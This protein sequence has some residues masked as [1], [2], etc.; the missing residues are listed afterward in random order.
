VPDRPDHALEDL[1]QE[2][3][4]DH[5]RRPRNKG[6]LEPHTHRVG[7]TNPSCGDELELDLVVAGDTISDVRFSGRGC[8][9]SQASASM[10]TQLIK[11]KTVVHAAVPAEDM[12]QAFAYRHLVPANDLWAFVAGR[13]PSQAALKI[14]TDLP[15]KIAAG[16]AAKVQIS[17]PALKAFEKVE[18]ELNEPPAGFS[19]VKASVTPD[20]ADVIVQC[21]GTKVKPGLKGNLIVNIFGVRTTRLPQGTLPAIPFEVIRP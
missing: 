3:I 21:D 15:L 14:R 11:G 6:T 16:Q 19:I 7:L 2:L 9:I 20:G 1:F 10:M 17:L 18:F 8:S 12:M 4:L 5:Y 13:G